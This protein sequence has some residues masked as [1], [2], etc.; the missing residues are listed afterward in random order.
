VIVS[1]LKEVKRKLVTMII[2]QEVALQVTDKKG[3][4]GK[5]KEERKC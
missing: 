1:H 3:G 4:K 5:G 2:R